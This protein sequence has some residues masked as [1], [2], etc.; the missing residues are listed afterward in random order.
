MTSL[1]KVSMDLGI[2]DIPDHFF[3]YLVE[4]YQNREFT[5]EDLK[6]DKNFHTPMKKEEKKEKPKTVKKQKKEKKV[7]EKPVKAPTKSLEE[8]QACGIIEGK[9]QCRVWK[10]GLDNIQCSGKK[11]DGTDYCSRHIVFGVNYWLGKVTEPRPEEPFGPN[12][13]KKPSRHH[14]NDQEKPTKTI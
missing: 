2:N 11:M 1:K 14:W 4:N 6:N 13:S 3:D 5:M 12:N 8:R 7:V 9:C 10:S